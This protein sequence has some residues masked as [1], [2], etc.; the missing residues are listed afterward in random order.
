[1]K[2]YGKLIKITNSNI[3][4]YEIKIG[5]S[6]KTHL[7]KSIDIRTVSNKPLKDLKINDEIYIEVKILNKK[8]NKIFVKCL[9]NVAFWV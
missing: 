1:M 4:P 7:I 5:G 2:L 3:Y 6:N 9:S 8:N